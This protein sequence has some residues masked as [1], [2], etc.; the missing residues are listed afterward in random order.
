MRP[1]ATAGA[2]AV[3]PLAIA[4]RGRIVRWDAV[5]GGRLTLDFTLERAGSWQV[6][7]VM[8]HRPDGAT[9][10]LRCDGAPLPLAAPRDAAEP[11]R[12][13]LTSAFAP[14]IL[15]VDGAPLRLAAGEHTIEIEAEQPGF[16]GID[17]LWIQPNNQEPR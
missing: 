8:T 2:V 14:R 12:I 1:R 5:A 17:Y 6:H 3:E 13:S 9:V 4:P 11:D 16:V 7:L 15:N 10:R